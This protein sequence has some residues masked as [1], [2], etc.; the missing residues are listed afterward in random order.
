M[1][2]FSGWNDVLMTYSITPIFAKPGNYRY[3]ALSARDREEVRRMTEPGTQDN[4]KI[5]GVLGYIVFLRCK[6]NDLGSQ[7]LSLGK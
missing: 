6:N 2:R 1:Q 7:L 5:C 4:L 3:F